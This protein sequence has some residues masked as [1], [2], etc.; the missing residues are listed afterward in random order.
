MNTD[1]E[2]FIALFPSMNLPFRATHDSMTYFDGNLLKD[3]PKP[4]YDKFICANGI[5]CKSD[6]CADKFFYGFKSLFKFYFS[7]DFYTILAAID[8]E[9]GCEEKCYLITYAPSGEFIEQMLVFGTV[10]LKRPSKSDKSTSNVDVQSVINNKK[11]KV[12]HRTYDYDNNNELIKDIKK[13]SEY[14]VQPDGKF[15]LINEKTEI[16]K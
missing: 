16:I 6:Y 4:L 3:I 13:T 11:I 8:N 12:V 14:M 2:A 1:F 9:A 5:K 15:K 10:S 7:K